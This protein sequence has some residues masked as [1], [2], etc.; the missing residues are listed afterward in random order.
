MP[1][2][3]S[4]QPGADV[5]MGGPGGA[6][7]KSLPAPTSAAKVLSFRMPKQAPQGA[8]APS[9]LLNASGAGG[10][11]SGGL[12]P[13]L[14]SMLLQAFSTPSQAGPFSGGGGGSASPSSAPSFGPPRVTP[15]ADGDPIR[16]D[17]PESQGP[18]GP[19]GQFFDRSQP[20][21]MAP[22]APMAPPQGDPFQMGQDY[23]SYGMMPDLFR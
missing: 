16:Y 8:L 1:M 2:G 13:Q 18:I 9:A 4:F 14:L 19:P 10:V 6:G 7:G 21:P 11:Q 20:M 23:Q 12:S 5:S 22:Q 17:G 3:F 15:G